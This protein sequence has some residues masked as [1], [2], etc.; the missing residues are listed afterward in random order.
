MEYY[1][2]YHNHCHKH[3][4][5]I[6]DTHHHN[7]QIINERILLAHLLTYFNIV[8][9]RLNYNIITLRRVHTSL[10]PLSFS[11]FNLIRFTSNPL[12]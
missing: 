1:Y 3:T 6:I 12:G 10:L 4:Y 7:H 9:S 11:R 5:M 2:D 8:E